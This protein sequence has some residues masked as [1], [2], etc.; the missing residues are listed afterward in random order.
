V[1]TQV[2]LALGRKVGKGKVVIGGEIFAETR[3]TK[4]AS[5]TTNPLR[6]TPAMVRCAL[7]KT[8]GQTGAGKI[9]PHGAWGKISGGK[10]PEST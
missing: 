3:R 4:G 9:S 2:Q 6:T 10:K 5:R 7:Q 1:F 8:T